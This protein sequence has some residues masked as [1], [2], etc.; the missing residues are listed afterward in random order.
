MPA[1]YFIGVDHKTQLE[2]IKSL[3]AS[4]ASGAPKDQMFQNE[5]GDKLT[6]IAESGKP[7]L[8]TEAMK[9]IPSEALHAAKIYSGKDNSLI[10]FEFDFGK[11]VRVNL[12]DPFQHEKQNTIHLYVRKNHPELPLS[13]IDK[14]ISICSERYLKAVNPANFISNFLLIESLKDSHDTK[15]ILKESDNKNSINLSIGFGNYDRRRIFARVCNYL[16]HENVKIQKVILETF[17]EPDHERVS[18]ISL[19]LDLPRTN[20][21]NREK[22]IQKW[23]HDFHRITYLDHWVLHYYYT[24]ESSWSLDEVEILLALANLSH[25]KLVKQDS[26]R[27]SKNRIIK[28]LESQS[29]LAKKIVDLFVLRFDP[30]TPLID[31]KKWNSSIKRLRTQLDNRTKTP[32]QLTILTTLLEAVALTFKTNLYIDGRY[33]LSL[34]ISPHFLIT[35][36]RD[37]VPYGA[38]YCYGRNFN[39]Y[40]VR[41]RDIARGGMRIVQTRNWEEFTLESERHFDEVYDLA[42]AQQ[43]KN[44][45]IPEGGAKAVVLVTP[46]ANPE[47]SGKVFADSLLDLTIQSEQFT[48]KIK[49]YFG[50]PEFIY[51]GPD[52]RVTPALINWVVKRA[53]QKGYPIP[54]AFM[55][56]KP[57][58]G[59]NHKEYGVTSEGVTVFLEAALRFKKIDPLRQQFSVKITGG[60]DGDVAGNEMRI[61]ISKYGKNVK[62][63]GIADGTGCAEDPNGLDN[64]EI[65]RLVKANLP[66]EKYNPKLLSEK[67][68]LKTMADED[69]AAFRN[70]MHNRIQTDVFVPAGGR[71]QTI[72]EKNWDQFLKDGKPS[73]PIIIEGANLF[74]TPKARIKLSESGALIVKD[75][76][77]NKCGVICSSF[78]ILASMLLNTDKFM[79]I[80]TEFI[81]E[82]LDRLRN[83]AKQEANALFKELRHR[84]KI[85]LPELSVLLSKSITRSKDALSTAFDIMMDNHPD[86]IMICVKRYLPKSLLN[87]LPSI[88][89]IRERIPVGYVRQIIASSLAS[90]IVYKEGINYFEYMDEHEIIALAIQYFETEL[91]NESL[92]KQVEESTLPDKEK[93]AS[94]LREGATGTKLRTVIS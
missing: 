93:I 90:T 48:S 45:D 71:P 94:L 44:K 14:H 51:L 6:F 52:E 60:P 55:S 66:I 84:P 86:W 53:E 20:E 43:L 7:G 61:L 23:L 70:T 38:F 25:Q 21:K 8:I 88:D 28:V 62:I 10:I 33:A 9:K 16:D 85:N 35:Q 77:A 78:E 69:G 34:R 54:N 4:D 72:N 68:I 73:S 17:E 59:I 91:S 18:L 24:Q 58:A 82:V 3:I 42:Y 19:I 83:L 50:K 47:F 75:S 57:G 63:C 74:I 81:Q 79:E 87:A 46:T 89:S 40:H 37:E 64:E 1:D 29:I 30:T 49:D 36:E 11:L 92:I 76:S 67:G 12:N 39:A 22:S 13:K 26:I 65:L 15:V 27:F 5:T 56:S 41:F 31:E 80:K 32:D 2:H